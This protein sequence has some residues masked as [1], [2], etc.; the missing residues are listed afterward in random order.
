MIWSRLVQYEKDMASPY[1]ELFLS[2]RKVILSF[3]EIEETRKERIT[4]FGIPEGGICH[5][6]TTSEGVDVGLLKG[7][8]LEDKYGL[9]HVRGSSKKIRVFSFDKLDSSKLKYYISQSIKIVRGE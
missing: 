7:S 8:I 6:R 2:A 4:T 9:L 1:K 5:M 3:K